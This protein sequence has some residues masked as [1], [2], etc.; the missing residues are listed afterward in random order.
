M[1]VSTCIEA[2]VYQKPNETSARPRWFPIPW[3]TAVS[4]DRI[5]HQGGRRSVSG[6]RGSAGDP[7]Y[8]ALRLTGLNLSLFGIGR[9]NSET[10]T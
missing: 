4:I 5:R 8:Q 3:A 1:V 7:H 6:F 9:A 10:G 2:F